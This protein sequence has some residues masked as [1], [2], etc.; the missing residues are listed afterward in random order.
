MKTAKARRQT[1]SSAFSFAGSQRTKGRRMKEDGVR[2]N[3]ID[4]EHIQTLTARINDILHFKFGMKNLRHR[5]I[6]AACAL[7]A[8]RNGAPLVGK[9][10]RGKFREAVSN[11]LGRISVRD[12][13]QGKKAVVL[14]EAFAK[15]EMNSDPR[16]C[17]RQATA[18]QRSGRR[19][20]RSGRAN[21]RLHEIQCMARRRYHGHFFQRIQSL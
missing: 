19:T 21:L 20:R 8:K 15:V 1:R 2:E 4:K 16:P 6:L 9:M 13:E 14:A 11:G 3:K 7:V 12:G 18:R 5:M 10:D 17:G